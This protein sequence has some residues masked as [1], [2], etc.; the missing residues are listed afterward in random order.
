MQPA[1]AYCRVKVFLFCLSAAPQLVWPSIARAQTTCGD[2]VDG[3]SVVC[4]TDGRTD[5]VIASTATANNRELRFDFAG[6]LDVV[7]AGHLS[8]DGGNAFVTLIG[9][10][11]SY[12]GQAASFTAP[13]ATAILAVS[14]G[15]GL[16]SFVLDDTIMAGT[17]LSAQSVD[18]GP[19]SITMTGGSIDAVWGI[20]AI[21]MQP[22]R[23]DIDIQSGASIVAHFPIA[24]TNTGE[25]HVIVSGTLRGQGMTLGDGDT[26]LELRPGFVIEG[27]VDALGGD[28]TLIWGGTG[29][30]SFSLDRVGSNQVNGIET[31]QYFDFQHFRKTGSSRWSISGTLRQALDLDVAQGVL[32]L[33]GVTATQGNVTV[34]SGA[35]L[36]G[37]GQL[38]DLTVF[39]NLAPVGNLWAGIVTFAPHSLLQVTSTSSG[40]DVLHTAAVNLRGATLEITPSAGAV[41]GQTIIT[42]TTPLTADNQFAAFRSVTPRYQPRVT[43]QSDR[44][45]IDLLATGASFTGF[46][47]TPEQAS[48]AT[49]L[50]SM[51][52][53]A[54]YYAALDTLPPDAVADLLA[55]LS[56]SDLEATDTALLHNTGML[57]AT[58]LGRLQQQAGLIGP[59]DSVLGYDDFVATPTSVTGAGLWGKLLASS[60]TA[61]GVQSGTMALL[62]G[63]DTP[64][65]GGFTVGLLAGV[66]RSSVASG[67][68]TSNSTDLS[69]GAYGASSLGGFDIRLG[70]SLTHHAVASS[71]RLVAPGID[72]TL[73]AA[74]GVATAQFLAELAHGFELGPVTL[75]LF[76]DLGYARNFAAPYSEQGGSGALTVAASSSDAV[77]TLLGARVSQKLALG[78]T[79]L[80]LAGSAAW[81]RRHTSQPATSQSFAGG[82]SFSTR[83]ATTTGNALVAGLDAH[84]DHSAHAGLDLSYRF[85]WSD[86]GTAQSIS[87]RYEHVF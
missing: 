66:G 35:T 41:S 82:G 86:T 70:T 60:A 23:I 47:R 73:T 81:K 29:Q 11:L 18:G 84:I 33:D 30:G 21:Q 57:N 43:Y 72:E 45:L 34:Q 12:Q 39:G 4:A 5:V 40:A 65:P 9:T 26:D 46:A 3:I 53:A 76:G 77:E 2:D 6:P 85:E 31:G 24:L 78:T 10:Q 1:D 54:P 27:P 32:T 15:P 37:N 75:E 61:A 62:A 42:T 49:L 20:E 50:D 13:H 55:Q 69:V 16:S 44:V 71:R 28:N 14:Q 7:N 79:L 25:S 22:G 67:S 38:P 19:L 74:Y 64:L 59:T 68:T 80:S 51:G 36:G 56:G 17:G 63:A 8:F 48:V 58:I 83:G 52:P 87:A